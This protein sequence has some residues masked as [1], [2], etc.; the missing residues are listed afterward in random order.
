MGGPAGKEKLKEGDTLMLR[1]P[2]PKDERLQRVLYGLAPDPQPLQQTAPLQAEPQ[3][4]GFVELLH[5]C[6]PALTAPLRR[7]RAV[8]VGGRSLNLRPGGFGQGVVA[9]RFRRIRMYGLGEEILSKLQRK[10][11]N[12][13][14]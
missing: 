10:S 7:S 2:M 1:F 5:T 11:K 3:P 9:E 4:T 14:V 12:K 13:K 6:A 8:R